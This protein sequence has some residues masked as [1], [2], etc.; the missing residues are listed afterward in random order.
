[1]HEFISDDVSTNKSLKNNFTDM[2]SKHLF[3]KIPV[4]CVIVLT[5]NT[6]EFFVTLMIVNFQAKFVC[7][8]VLYL[9]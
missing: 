6:A 1:M 8:P 4:L 5:D 2:A 9:I 7:H 3:F